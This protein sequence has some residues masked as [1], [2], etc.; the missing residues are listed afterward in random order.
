MVWL[1]W[2]LHWNAKI[3]GLFRGEFGQF[4]VKSSKMRESDFFVKLLGQHV[5]SDWVLGGVAPELDLGEHLV[6][7]GVGH[8]KAG[9]THGTAMI[10]K[11][12][13]SEKDDVLAILE[14]VSVNL[15]L[16]I[17][18]QLAVL[19]QPL[20]LDLA[21]K[22]TDVADNGVVLHLEEVFAGEDVLA[23]GGGHEDVASG[24]SVVHGGD[25]VALAGGLESVDG[26]NLCNDDATA[27][28]SE[29][30]SASLADISV[31][32]NKCN[33]SCQHDICGSLDSINK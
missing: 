25:L 7:E 24:D 5:D 20:D 33:L 18:L 23:A 15:G 27:E 2:T 19:L 22:V 9:V 26:V 10:D 32:G 4:N 11:T 8:D 1:V 6:G 13:L 12:T 28:S 16:D 14:C 21:V 31:S 29:R 3:V 17:G 30:S